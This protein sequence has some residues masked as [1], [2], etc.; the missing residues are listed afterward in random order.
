[1][2]SEI[3][4]TPT[5]GAVLP[6]FHLEWGVAFGDTEILVIYNS[7]VQSVVQGLVSWCSMLLFKI[8]EHGEKEHFQSV[9]YC[10]G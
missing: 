8:S 2:V 1:M 10:Y 4:V 7:I 6:N 5:N 9:L 3:D